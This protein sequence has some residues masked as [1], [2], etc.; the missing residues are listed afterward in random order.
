MTM[1]TLKIL[2]VLLVGL[3]T[4]IG[5]WRTVTVG[6]EVVKDLRFLRALR[7]LSD[8]RA[9]ERRRQLPPPTPQVP[10]K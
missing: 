7:H 2:A 4:L 1:R 3:L 5:G 9:E 10:G 6:G 8:Q